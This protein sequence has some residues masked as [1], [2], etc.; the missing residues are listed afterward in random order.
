[1]CRHIFAKICA[2]SVCLLMC[3]LEIT[4][5]FSVISIL[6]GTSDYVPWHASSGKPPFFVYGDSVISRWYILVLNNLSM[7]QNDCLVGIQT[8]IFALDNEC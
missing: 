7:W 2:T 1:M 6:S 5:A 4:F 3:F 8:H